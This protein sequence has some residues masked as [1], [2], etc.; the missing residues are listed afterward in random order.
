MSE[1]SMHRFVETLLSHPKYKLL[2][3]PATISYS[4]REYLMEA[5]NDRYI[6]MESDY[7]EHILEELKEFYRDMKS[8]DFFPYD[9]EL[10][11]Q[12]DGRIAMIDFDK[13]GQY[14]QED[15]MI[16][17]DSVYRTYSV[18][19]LLKSQLLPFGFSF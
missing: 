4:D 15:G 3:V 6:I 8:H 2:Y 9:Y 17:I 1:Y 16:V 10:Y 13:F 5:I 14:N 19:T 12:P 18:E 11:L 7:N